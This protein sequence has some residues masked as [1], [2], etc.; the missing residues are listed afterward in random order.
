MV[1]QSWHQCGSAPRPRLAQPCAADPSPPTTSSRGQA[2]EHLVEEGQGVDQGRG[3][4][5]GEI[6][7]ADGG[8]DL[9]TAGR[10]ARRSTDDV[11]VGGSWQH[12]KAPQAFLGGGVGVGG[13]RAAASSAVHAA[14]PRMQRSLQG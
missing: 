11:V 14:A 12:S 7:V 9:R 3:V 2:C 1:L 13:G 6:A 8:N 10:Q 4:R 5:C